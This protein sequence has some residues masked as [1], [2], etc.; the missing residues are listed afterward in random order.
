MLGEKSRHKS[1]TSFSRYLFSSLNICFQEGKTHL[2]LLSTS[3]RSCN[4]ISC[5]D[6]HPLGSFGELGWEMNFTTPL[7][8]SF[9]TFPISH[10]ALWT[11]QRLLILKNI[12][13]LGLEKLKLI[14]CLFEGVESDKKSEGMPGLTDSKPPRCLDGL[15]D[16]WVIPYSWGQDPALWNP[17]AHGEGL[18]PRYM[19]SLIEKDF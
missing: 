16:E 19:I 7:L 2:K 18:L 15:K 17:W 11:S 4:S 13:D 8:F 1:S 10:I 6:A 9:F 5:P 12:S 3:P 14:N